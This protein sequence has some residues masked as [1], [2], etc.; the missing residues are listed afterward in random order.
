MTYCG[1]IIEAASECEEVI[2]KGLNGDYNKV[3]IVWDYLMIH[4]EILELYVQGIPV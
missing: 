4:V 3:G 1:L 2:I